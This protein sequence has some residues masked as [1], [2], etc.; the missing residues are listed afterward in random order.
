V[1]A[2]QS[3]PDLTARQR[4]AAAKAKRRQDA[5]HKRLEA[6]EAK[7][8]A[9]DARQEQIASRVRR[10]PV[11]TATGEV[12]RH[13]VLEPAG[14]GFIHS[15]PIRHLM[16]R[17]GEASLITVEHVVVC[18]RLLA[19]WT[20]AG[21]TITSGVSSYGDVRGGDGSATGA[22]VLRQAACHAEIEAVVLFLGGCWPVVCAVALRGLTI[23]GWASEVRWDRKA[24][25]G[26]LK[27]GLDRLVEFYARDDKPPRLR[28]AEFSSPRAN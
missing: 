26:F 20:I 2:V 12:Y 21:E 23:T 28:S 18:Q 13:P 4:K 19:T 10:S 5:H 11:L 25:L 8:R 9:E 24:A 27:A 16:A 1:T 6:A 15:N 14:V 22:M 3:A 17:G 7:A